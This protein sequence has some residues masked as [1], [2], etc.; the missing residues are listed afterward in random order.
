M[1]C[2]EPYSPP[3]DLERPR[4]PHEEVADLLA[5]GI[6]RLRAA[7]NTPQNLGEFANTAT[8]ALGFTGHQRVNANPYQKEGVRA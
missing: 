2:I 8:V 3:A 7:S 6:L 4:H 1:D 5:A